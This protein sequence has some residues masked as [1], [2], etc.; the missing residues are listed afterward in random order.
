MRDAGIE[1]VLALRGDPPKGETEFKP[2]PGGLSYG[3]ELAALISRVLRLLHRRRVLPGGAPRGAGRGYGP[4][5]LH[6]KVGAGASFLITQLFFDNDDYFDFVERARASGIDVPIIAGIMPITNFEQ[7][8]RFTT[9]VRRD[10]PARASTSSSRP[11]TRRATRPW[12]SSASRTRPCSA[13]T[14]S[15]AARPASTSTR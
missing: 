7:I 14:C 4:A 1:N 11:G 9:H 15:R 6:Y 12:P 5:H 3:S 10:D 13:P 8:K 2:A